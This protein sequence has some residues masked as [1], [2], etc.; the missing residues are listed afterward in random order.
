MQVTTEL[1]E[2]VD[3]DAAARPD[4]SKSAAARR[5]LTLGS[6]MADALVLD[7]G[8]LLSPDRLDELLDAAEAVR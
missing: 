7:A 1:A 5:L 6:L 4:G 3:T 2:R 8:N